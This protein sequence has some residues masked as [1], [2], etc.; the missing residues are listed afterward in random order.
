MDYESLLQESDTLGLIVKEKPLK[1][2]DGRIK[3]C[4]IAIRKDIPTSIE[5]ACVLSEELGHYYTSSGD[6]LNQHDLNNRKQEYKARLAAYDKMIG[7]KGIIDACKYGCHSRYDMAE[8]L[9]V[10]ESFLSDALNTYKAKYGT[11]VTLND[12]ILI[13][14]PTFAIIKLI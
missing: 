2:N 12:Y 5:K 4:K 3:G 13:L 6:I 7:L 10:T 14:D 1:F 9:R 8:Y 11:Y